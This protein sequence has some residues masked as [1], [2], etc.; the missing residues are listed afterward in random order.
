MSRLTRHDILKE[1]SFMLAVERVRDFLARRQKQILLALAG[2]AI[3]VLAVIAFFT[4][5]ASRNEAAQQAL[6]DALKTFRASVVTSGPPPQGSELTFK[7]SSE[8]Y[9]KAL[10]E[11]QRVAASRPPAPVGKIANYY[12]GLCFVELGRID[13]A[14][15]SLEPLSKE[16]SDYGALAIQAM[17]RAYEASGNLSQA[18]EMYRQLAASGSQLTPKG[19]SLMRLA[20]L[21]ELQNKNSEATKIYQQII[22]ELPGTPL[23]SEAEQRIGQVGQ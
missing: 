17:A 3:I 12:T 8:K 11:F 9:S 4:Y 6:S 21:Y 10:E 14:V 20:K 15:K 5:T 16:K 18:T 13:E 7:S 19:Q 2:V 22:K 23:A 1:D